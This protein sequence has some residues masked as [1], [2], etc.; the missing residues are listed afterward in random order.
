MGNVYSGVNTISFR[1]HQR[2]LQDFDYMV[3]SIGFGIRVRTPVG[4]IRAR[5]QLQPEPA[6]IFRIQRHSGRSAEGARR[7]A[8]VLVA[9]TVADVLESA[10][11]LV[12][13]PFFSGADV[14]NSMFA[15][16]LVAAGLDGVARLWPLPWP[17]P[18]RSTASPS[19]WARSVI[20]E[21]QVILDLRVAAFLERKPV[22]LSGAAKRQSAER[23]VD[24]LL[25]LREAV[26]SHVTLPSTEA[27]AGLVAPYAAESD[28]RAE[29]GALRDF[30][31]RSGCTPAGGTTHADLHRPAV[32]ARSPGFA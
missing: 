29:S 15:R 20:T 16:C 8:S 18:R 28:Y 17:R 10:H 13:V 6:A 11:Q 25:I 12:S 22:D 27:T 21:S 4:P 32:P 26:D 23:L 2:N 7:S 19:A 9:D 1:F 30:G 31:A 24:Q 3:H 5:F 14:L